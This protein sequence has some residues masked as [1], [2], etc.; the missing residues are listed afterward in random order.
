M[1]M[2][3]P[4]TS[5][6]ETLV[7]SSGAIKKIQLLL[8][9][10]DDDVQD[11]ITS[12]IDKN[13]LNGTGK[14]SGA[15]GEATTN[16]WKVKLRNKTLGLAEGDLAFKPV[17]I[18]FT[19]DSEA[20]TTIFSGFV[21]QDG[22]QRSLAQSSDIVQLTFFDLI[23][24]HGKAQAVG[25]NTYS[26]YQVIKPADTANSLLH[27]LAAQ[28]GIADADVVSVNTAYSPSL[29]TVKEGAKIVKEMQ[30]LARIYNGILKARYDGKLLLENR[31]EDSYS[32]PGY[33]W[34]IAADEIRTITSKA[35]RE[36]ANYIESDYKEYESVTGVTIFKS[37]ED[38]N[39]ETL[40]NEITIP[41]GEYWRGNIGAIS[42]CKYKDPAS[43]EE[44][45]FATNI[46][47]PTIGLTSEF[48]IWQ[49]QVGIEIIAFNGSAVLMGFTSAG[50]VNCVAGDIGKTVQGATSLNTGTLKDYDNTK[51]VWWIETSDTWVGSES[52]AVLTGTGQGTC[53]GLPTECAQGVDYS[54][55]VVKNTAGSPTVIKQFKI[56]GDAYRVVNENYVRSIDGDISNKAELIKKT[57]PGKYAATETQVQDAL[58]FIRARS[59]ELREFKLTLDYW[60]PQ[61][62]E[63]A[64]VRLNH[65]KTAEVV[66]CYVHQWDHPAPGKFPQNRVTRLVLREK[67]SLSAAESNNVTV[68]AV[69]NVPA[70][71]PGIQR[72]I[73]TKEEIV[74]GFVEPVTG[75]TL[76]PAVP[77]IVQAISLEL[78][79]IL[80]PDTQPLLTNFDR[81]EW[82]V[83]E[84]DSTWHSLEFDGTDWKDTLDAVTSLK[85]D[86]GQMIHQPIP[87]ITTTPN[88]VDDPGNRTLYYR[89]RRVTKADTGSSWS[90]S[91][92]CT[93]K[94][95]G[96]GTIAEQSIY[97][98]QIVATEIDSIL[99]NVSDKAYIGFR[100][101]TGTTSLSSPGEGDTVVLIDEDEFR[102]MEYLNSTW[103]ARLKVGGEESGVFLSI[104]KSLGIVHPE[105]TSSDLVERHPHPDGKGF[106]CEN[107]YDDQD[108]FDEWDTKT[109]LQ[110]NTAYKKFG[111]YSLGATSGNVGTLLRDD[112]WTAGESQ[113][114]GAW[115]YFHGTFGTPGDINIVLFNGDASNK[116]TLK[117]TSAQKVAAEIVIGGTTYTATSP[118]TFTLA[119]LNY[120]GFVYDVD[121]NK[122]YVVLNNTY[123]EASTGGTWGSPSST[124]IELK[125][126]D[127]ANDGFD[128]DEIYVAPDSVADYLLF[129]AHYNHGVAWN[130]EFSARDLVVRPQDGGK[131]WFDG[132]VGKQSRIEIPVFNYQSNRSGAHS[133]A[134]N[135]LT[136]TDWPDGDVDKQVDLDATEYVADIEL[137]AYSDSIS[138][139]MY[140][141][142]K[143]VSPGSTT[144]YLGADGT[145]E[146]TEGDD[147]RLVSNY[148]YSVSAVSIY[149]QKRWKVFFTLPESGVWK[150]TLRYRVG[151]ASNWST[152]GAGGAIRVTLKPVNALGGQGPAGEPGASGG[153]VYQ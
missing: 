102:Y 57:V 129:A 72:E 22:V 53:Y 146:S 79:C 124:S 138:D 5:T 4:V 130:M 11:D 61:V 45:A 119:G 135:S 30:D 52:I 151:A 101:V 136:F 15:S 104:M 92:T 84:D 50:Y 67:E 20:Y 144:Y 109:N 142:I 94:A 123:A 128:F 111:T 131:I 76:T 110:F 68:V 9:I 120:V 48:D 2:F 106:D 117:F 145:L 153:L 140:W 127:V 125:P 43:G 56:R 59:A 34:E 116:I 27:I 126:N 62:Q 14:L 91:V 112:W 107:D 122:L 143:L 134:L 86:G 12:Y 95:I 23:G 24:R 55:I 105:A 36:Q 13:S 137:G 148:V 96:S 44:Y 114:F 31:F 83:S 141:S 47:T 63:G 133:E 93:A 74:S 99:L 51:R 118:G 26:G 35:I 103:Q 139:N 113:A 87:L 98:N 85:I 152:T 25:N 1:A 3:V 8:D 147:Y 121:N 73:V 149:V 66:D 108:G 70:A 150:W 64:I 32:E 49:S 10:D 19:F 17:T 69:P 40:E 89:C 33:E 39:S 80:K 115:V 81:I 60:L 46:V 21:T 38:F 78:G 58:T 18:K 7:R 6:I 16:Q 29:V 41:A 82:Q 54:S 77:S 100:S 75:A 28:L 90:T 42:E 71:A 65:P 132:Q 37:T 88:S 97:A